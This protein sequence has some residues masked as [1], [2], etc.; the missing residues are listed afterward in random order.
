[1]KRGLHLL[2]A[3]LLCASIA[4][5]SPLMGMFQMSGVVTA[6]ITTLTWAGVDGTTPDVFTL[7]LGTGSFAS[8]NGQN[9]IHDLDSATE[10]VGSVF[11]P[12]QFINFGVTPGLPSLMVNFIPMGN[13]G[14]AGCSQPANGT[15]PPQ[16]CTPVIPGGSPITF[17][18][19]NDNGAVTGSSATWTLSGVTSDG[20]SHWTAIFTS[21]FV[22]Q[23]YQD[24]LATLAANG[25]VTDAYSAN[26]SVTAI[27]E[28]QTALMMGLGV[29]LVIFG[30][31]RRRQA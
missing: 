28:P 1:M 24:V 25:H 20:L 6:T 19:N 11:P 14:A 2:L 15:V 27:P 30:R 7:A 22:G 4:M 21:Q 3:S 13:G 31:L 8:E 10:P 17:Q 16:T 9:T 23:P 12:Q 26:V 5:A 18:N 29:L